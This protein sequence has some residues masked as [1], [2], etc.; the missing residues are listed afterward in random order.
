MTE[1]V[2][3]VE[4]VRRYTSLT[5]SLDR[6][7]SRRWLGGISYT[8]SRLFG[9]Y[10]GLTSSEEYGRPE[11]QVWNFHY[12]PRSIEKNVFK[13]NMT[14]SFDVWFKTFDHNGEATLGLLPTDR[15][16][17]IKAYGAYAFDFGLTVGF[18]GFAMSGTPVQTDVY[19]YEAPAWF[20]LGRG[21][22]G[23]SHWLWQLNAYLEF[24]L[25]LNARLLLQLSLNIDNVTD[26]STARWIHQLFNQFRMVLDQRIIF[27]G[28]D[29]IDMVMKTSS[30]RDPRFGMGRDFQAPIAAR[31]GAKLLF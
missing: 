7:F 10:S 12:I 29:A 20:P 19:V 18:N 22:L 11:P 3:S 23:R 1:G 21:D 5:V 26:N 8:W 14:G 9:N 15:T 27:D 17:Q 6:R 24:N 30:F 13:P 4:A 31:L 28:F 2:E 16:H 25:K